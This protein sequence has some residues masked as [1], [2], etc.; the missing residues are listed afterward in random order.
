MLFF[1]WWED[2]NLPHRLWDQH[3]G[4]TVDADNFVNDL[5]PLNAEVLVCRPHGRDKKHHHRRHHHHHRR[6]SRHRRR[7]HHRHRHHHH[8]HPFF[9]SLIKS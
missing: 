6:R 3:F 4:T 5:D 1:N 2:P 7:R 8:H 9:K